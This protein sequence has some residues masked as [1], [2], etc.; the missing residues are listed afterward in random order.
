MALERATEEPGPSNRNVSSPSR[1]FTKIPDS[2]HGKCTCTLSNS[3]ATELRRKPCFIAVALILFRS[4][5]A[6]ECNPFRPEKRTLQ[7]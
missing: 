3:A 4:F 6:D 5:V 1:P 2:Q 7:T